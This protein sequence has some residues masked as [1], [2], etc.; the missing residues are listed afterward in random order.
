MGICNKMLITIIII[1]III[2]TNRGDYDTVEHTRARATRRRYG[3]KY[4][5]NDY[6]SR[7][8]SAEIEYKSVQE[9]ERQ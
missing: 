5:E 8:W 1:I 3:R 7:Q 2:N 4:F 6:Y 9:I